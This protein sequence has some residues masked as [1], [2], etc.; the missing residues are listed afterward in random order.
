M[1]EWG[2]DMQAGKVLEMLVENR[3]TPSE[4][5]TL[6][7]HLECAKGLALDNIARVWRDKENV[8][9]VEYA[10]GSWFHYNGKG[11]WY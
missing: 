10:N 1:K 8:L 9:C 3:A 6:L 11:E 4:K 5:E 2:E 7:M